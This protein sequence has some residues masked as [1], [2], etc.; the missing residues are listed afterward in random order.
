MQTIARKLNLH[1]DFI[2]PA[3]GYKS[4]AEVA[5]TIEW[6]LGCV[7]TSPTLP[8]SWFPSSGQVET[9]ILCIVDGLG[10]QQFG[11]LPFS[12][13]LRQL[14]CNRT[15][16]S[17]F[18]STTPVCLTSLL[19]GGTSASLGMGDF[20]QYLSPEEFPD[21]QGRMTKLIPFASGGRSLSEFGFA[22]EHIFHGSTL[23]ERLARVGKTSVVLSPYVEGV[24]AD[25]TQR[26]ATERVL[27]PTAESLMS[28]LVCVM[29][30]P[31]RPNL[32]V[33]YYPDVDVLGHTYGPDSPEQLHVIQNFVSLLT[34]FCKSTA[35]D[36]GKTMLLLTADHGQ[37]SLESG[38]ALYLDSPE[39]AWLADR[40]QDDGVGGTAPLVTW[41]RRCPALYVR[42]ELVNKSVRRLRRQLSGYADVVRVTDALAAGLYGPPEFV[43]SRFL[44]RAGTVLILPYDGYCIWTSGNDKKGTHGGLTPQEMY[45]PLFTAL[46]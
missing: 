2:M 22:P 44:R 46:L 9:V 24:Y 31:K 11:T 42:H 28:N 20:H 13:Q 15:V 40:L 30:R 7:P 10:C 43:S 6:L 35:T 36:S 39:F 33:V 1:A 18:P 5:P 3:Y 14:G 29:A 17:L 25:Q 16:T 45:V 4:I 19:T 32:V 23:C 38:S 26:G 21:G 12:R 8:L 41:S 37:M 27:S 34:E